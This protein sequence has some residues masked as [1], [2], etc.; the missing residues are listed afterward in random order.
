[1]AEHAH[2]AAPG[3]YGVSGEF[4]TAEALASAFAALRA[5]GIGRLEAYS[6]VPVVGACEPP[7]R[8]ASIAP[9]AALGAIAG[10]L[11]FFALIIYATGYDYVFNIGGRPVFSWPYYIIPS[12]SFAMLAGTVLV[13]AAMLFLN[14]LPRLSHPAFTIPGFARA[15]QDRFFLCV[16]A[17]DGEFDA[18]AVERSLAELAFP[19]LAVHRVPK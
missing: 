13:T 15:S 10:G 5:R 7:R 16:E 4:E 1:M 11:G 19:P 14:R 9:V 8:L 17:R 2:E 3:L 6:P 12:F 18:E